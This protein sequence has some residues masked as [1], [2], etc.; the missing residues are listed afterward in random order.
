MEA[1]KLDDTLDAQDL[2]Q[3]DAALL[4]SS[5]SSTSTSKQVRFA[6]MYKFDL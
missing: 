2:A 6:V 5:L 1:Y 4:Y 3:S